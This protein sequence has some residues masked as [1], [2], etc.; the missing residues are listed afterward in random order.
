[1]YA[2]YPM[3]RNTNNTTLLFRLFSVFFACL[4]P[5]SSMLIA[6]QSNWQ[7]HYERSGKLA[8][9]R[10]A[11]TMAFVDSLRQH[12]PLIHTGVFGQSPQQRDLIYAVIDKEGLDNPEAIHASG[13]LLLMVQAGIHPGESEG[14]D[15]MLLLLRDMLVHREHLHLLDKV[16][17]LFIPIFNV[18]GHER[19][20]PYGRINQNGPEEMGWRTTAQNLNLNRDFLKADSPEMKAWLGLFNKWNPHFFIDTHTTDGADYQY[21]LTYGLETG[22]NMT[23]PLTQWQE[24][25]YLPFVEQKM[26]KAG[27]LIFPYVSF[28]NWH[29]PRSGLVL[30]LAGPMYSQGYTAL[31]NRPGLLV[32]TH[33]LKPYQPRVESTYAII[34]ST[35]ELLNKQ[36]DTLGRLIA[37]A[38]RYVAS[39]AFRSK[40]FP[41]RF[42]PDMTDSTMVAFKGFEYRVDSSELTGGDWFVYQPDKPAVFSLPMFLKSRV[43]ESVMLPETYV[44]PVQWT[45]AISRLALH[46]VKMFAL[47][48][49]RVF[50]AEA[51][52]F[53]LV[54]WHTRPYEGRHRMAKMEFKPVS[55]S[56]EMPAGSMV[57][58]MNQPLAPVIAQLLEPR[59]NGSLLEWGFFDAIFEQ[60]EY[61]ESY[62]MEPLARRMLDSIP[63]LKMAYEA[64]KIADPA[65]AKNSWAQLN[66]F[67]QHTPWWDN[68]YMIYPVIRLDTLPT[69]HEN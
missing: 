10:Y 47:P 66:W 5:I 43:T 63:G 27:F 65:F 3:K 37:E 68:R 24:E 41:L 35:L 20:G 1:M 32:E 7:T 8:T 16:S 19:F 62:V 26:D 69:L 4:F 6:Q 50:Q 11:A 38:D 57:V 59:G 22:G 44:V 23:E 54:E 28:R 34:V 48:E 46:G 52:S 9:P 39:K 67:Y 12:S 56:L 13:R 51:D 40:P 64:R 25:V 61:A 45:E 29:D 30:G 49:A 53:S 18:D 21:H 36:V 17:I 42:A 58:P 55:R 60:K 15:A 33:M 14:K 2:A 31:R